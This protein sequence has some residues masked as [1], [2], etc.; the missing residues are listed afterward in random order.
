M[1]ETQKRE[2][3]RDSEDRIIAAFRA[4]D[5]EASPGCPEYQ[6]AEAQPAA[7]HNDG[8]E[9]YNLDDRFAQG[10]GYLEPEF[11]RELLV[12]KGDVFKPD[13][14]RRALACASSKQPSC[15]CG[16]TQLPWLPGAANV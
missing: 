15:C 10:K 7:Q 5:V 16:E 1:M 12:T 4:L 3:T 8:F 11:L 2:L 13:E 6:S 14:A 9:R